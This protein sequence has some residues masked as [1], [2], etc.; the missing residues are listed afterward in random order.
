M[1]KSY[2]HPVGP[3]K[4]QRPRVVIVN[5]PPVSARKVLPSPGMHLECGIL[6]MPLDAKTSRG[7]RYAS[8]LNVKKT[9]WGSAFPMRL[10][11]EVANTFEVLR[12]WLLRQWG[13]NV[14]ALHG[15]NQYDTRCLTTQAQKLGIELTF[16]VPYSPE[17]N[18]I[19]ERGE[20]NVG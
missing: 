19:G 6:V 1:G 15:D 14:M 8:M 5:K 16:S 9:R 17:L 7:E 12:M 10:R 18:P 2:R 4:P 20:S 11:S 13:I 3:C